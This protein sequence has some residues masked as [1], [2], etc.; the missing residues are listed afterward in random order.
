MKQLGFDLARM[1]TSGGLSTAA[2]TDG[3]L[4]RGFHAYIVIIADGEIHH[5]CVDPTTEVFVGSGTAVRPNSK[6]SRRTP[7]PNLIHMSNDCKIF[8]KGSN[9]SESCHCSFY[10]EE[11][12]RKARLRKNCK[13]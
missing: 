2:T 11:M 4:L 5:R 12:W 9:L 3:L 10:V 1:Q 6:L 8:N 7:G 13:K